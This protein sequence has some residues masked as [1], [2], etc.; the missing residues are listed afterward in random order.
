MRCR[1]VATCLQ[2]ASGSPMP[3]NTTLVTRAGPPRAPDSAAAIAVRTCSTISAAERLRVSP[4]CPVAQKGQAM[5][6][7]AWEETH[8]VVLP[9]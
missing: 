8:R 6:Q 7:P 3:M 9:G 1:A 5:P 4:D 2:L